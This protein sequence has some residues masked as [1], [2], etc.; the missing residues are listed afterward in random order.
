[1]AFCD[2]IVE[3]LDKYGERI[4]VTDDPK[5]S[6][7]E[8]LIEFIILS[9][10]D[11]TT[12]G[13]DKP[14]TIYIDKKSFMLCTDEYFTLFMKN[15]EEPCNTCK[16]GKNKTVLRCRECESPWWKNYEPKEERS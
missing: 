6:E 5:E 3:L 14:V 12:L 13:N 10:E 16:Y 9:R 7:E 15:C 2:E 11:M 8:K 1:M 4:F